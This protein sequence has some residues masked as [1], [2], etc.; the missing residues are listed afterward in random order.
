MAHYR[1][2]DTYHSQQKPGPTLTPL[3]TARPGGTIRARFHKTDY[4]KT[5]SVEHFGTVTAARRLT[6]GAKQPRVEAVLWCKPNEAAQVAI[7][8]TAKTRNL[9]AKCAVLVNP[10]QKTPTNKAPRVQ[11]IEGGHA[12][13]GDRQIVRLLED[14][15]GEAVNGYI[16]V[17]DIA[18][19]DVAYD[20]AVSIED[21]ARAE[22]LDTCVVVAHDQARIDRAERCAVVLLG[23]SE[24]IGTAA[25]C[26]IAGPNTTL[27]RH[28]SM[29]VIRRFPSDKSVIEALAFADRGRQCDP[30]TVLVEAWY[31][32]RESLSSAIWDLADN[33]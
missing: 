33:N 14:S 31:N 2:D 16:G 26:V 25:S 21:G 20:S 18:A 24:L 12:K 7:F 27:K 6:S 3:R 5:T 28:G 15:T 4:S 32:G 1:Y 9:C 19:L 8:E 10:T 22:H 13:A 17:E 30:A 29:T 23:H 11:I